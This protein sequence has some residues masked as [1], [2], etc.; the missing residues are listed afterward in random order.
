MEN[1]LLQ[2]QELMDLL[3][4]SKEPPYD[5]RTPMAPAPEE[6]NYT[7]MDGSQLSMED[8]AR[9][10]Q[11]FEPEF[12]QEDIDNAS[13]AKSQMDEY[14]KKVGAGQTPMPGIGLG[15]GT[16][17]MDVQSAQDVK[18]L[19]PD[20]RQ[21]AGETQNQLP[22][23][24]P[25][26]V[27]ASAKQVAPERE[28]SQQ[29]QLFKEYLD[30]KDTSSR[31]IASGYE[32][33]RKAAIIQNIVEG[34]GK[35]YTYNRYATTGN[36]PIDINIKPVDFKYAEQ[37]KET[38]KNKLD[39]YK[40]L[41]TALKTSKSSNGLRPVIKEIDGKQQVVSMNDDNEIEL[42]PIGEV[43]LTKKERDKLE[44]K[45]KENEDKNNRFNISDEFRKSDQGRKLNE[46]F[47]DDV[48]NTLKD[49]RQKD[50]WKSGEKTLSSIPNL[51]NLLNDAYEKGGQSLSMV[52]PLVAKGIAGEVGV[53]TDQDVTRYVKNPAL[54][55]GLVDTLE[56]VKSGRLSEASYDN[57]TRLMDISEKAAKDKI[58]RAI[59]EEAKLLSKREKIDY[60]EA[61][62]YLDAEYTSMPE[63]QK[64]VF[65]EAQEQSIELIMNKKSVDRDT[66]VKLLQE[67]GRLPK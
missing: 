51:R 66:A 25:Q 37:A 41:L 40:D 34:L 30:A 56:K 62:G 10:P 14:F 24:S 45:N 59:D 7:P 26:E 32:A 47:A 39:T 44:F 29:E 64:R 53:M 60:K 31:E 46:K 20:S 48:R 55:P 6:L 36:K 11:M 22:V 5:D 65:S 27:A 67:A 3:N 54:I 35:A 43:S 13:L 42:T 18:D 4:K 1:K 28:L 63:E 58:N 38:N 15:M 49:M 16:D 61:R 19:M 8:T 57:L 52:G 50:T 33:D 12:S 2:Y 9:E 23:A 17:Q 21:I